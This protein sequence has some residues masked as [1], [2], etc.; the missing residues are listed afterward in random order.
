MMWK[1]EA[2]RIDCTVKNLFLCLEEVEKL[3]IVPGKQHKLKHKG[4][5]QND[6]GSNRI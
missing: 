6:T 4:G 5:I 3:G 1:P 2:L